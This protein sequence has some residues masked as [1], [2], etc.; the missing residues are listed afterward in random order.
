M[1]EDDYEVVEEILVYAEFQTVLPEELFECNPLIKIIGLDSDQPV[2][3]IGHQIHEGSWLDIPGTA[4]IFEEV[5]PTPP[6]DKLFTK[7]TAKTLKYVT[8]TR[9]GL[10][11]K[12]VF[13]TPKEEKLE[14]EAMETENV[15]VN[16]Q[17]TPV[18]RKYEALQEEPMVI[19][20]Q[21]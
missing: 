15:D 8:K 1:S 10:F 14:E 17:K 7:T 12:R 18:Q 5:E 16:S 21:Q 6:K 3:Q 13:T 20:L 9:K 2:L 4:L 11:L 19:V